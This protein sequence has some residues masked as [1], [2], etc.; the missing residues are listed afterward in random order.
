[1]VRMHNVGLDS[2]SGDCVPDELLDVS[3]A[4]RPPGISGIGMASLE[5]ASRTSCWLQLAVD[6]CGGLA[7]GPA[8]TSDGLS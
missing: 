4:R 1:M 3:E 5:G 6:Q 8:K 2:R 7:R